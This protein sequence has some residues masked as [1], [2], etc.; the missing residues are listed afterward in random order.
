MRH[1]FYHCIS[2]GYLESDANSLR[3][4]PDN[5]AGDLDRFLVLRRHK[6]HCYFCS[7]YK[8]F[9]GFNKSSTNTYVV[10]ETPVG[11]TLDSKIYSYRGNSSGMLPFLYYSHLVIMDV[12]FYIC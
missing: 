10:N 6:C 3:A 5:L 8:G 4:T 7:D 11:T 1:G 9:A 2:L 12:S